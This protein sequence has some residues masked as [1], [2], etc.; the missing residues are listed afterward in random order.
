[1]W[2]ALRLEFGLL[3]WNFYSGSLEAASFYKSP[4]VIP[5]HS[6][7]SRD[8]SSLWTSHARTAF[9]FPNRRYTVHNQNAMVTTLGIKNLTLNQ[10]VNSGTRKVPH[11]RWCIGYATATKKGP[12]SVSP[13][14]SSHQQRVTGHWSH[15]G[16]GENRHTRR[17]YSTAWES[18]HDHMNNYKGKAINGKDLNNARCRG[19]EKRAAFVLEGRRRLWESALELVSGRRTGGSLTCSDHLKSPRTVKAKS[20]REQGD[21]FKRWVRCL[22]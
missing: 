12:H 7:H 21:D 2:K 17:Q 16:V 10:G 9:L 8:Q 19:A 11:K 20:Q 14:V 18:L 6:D 1:M 15:Q 3:T 4:L 5:G 22:V 13:M